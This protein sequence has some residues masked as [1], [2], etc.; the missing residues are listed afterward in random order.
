M[1]TSFI[2]IVFLF[3]SVTQLSAQ[4]ITGKAAFADY[5][6]QKPRVSRKITVADLPEP[7]PA[8]AVDNGPKVVARPEGVMP[9]APPGFTVSIY[10]GGDGGPTPAPDG[11]YS[12]RLGT[13]VPKGT[14]QQPRIIRTAP[15][16]DIFLSDSF[17]GKVYVLR[18]MKADGH[19]AT[20]SL[21]AEELKNPFGIAFYPAK[22]PKWVYVAN[23][24]T[25]V[26]F[27]YKDGDLVASG[28]PETLVSDLPGYA[29]L[30]GGGHW[31]R[32]VVFTP[33]ESHMLISVGSASNADNADDH[34]NE[35][36]RADVLEFTPEGK[37]VEVYASGIRNCVGEAINPVTGSLWCSTNERDNLGNNLVPDYI[38]SVK[39]GGFYGWPWYYMGGHRDPRLELPCAN[40]TAFYK[41][42]KAP[43]TVEQAK[44]CERKDMAAK[45]ITPDVLL[46][47]HM[48]SLGMTFYTPGAGASGA[49]PKEYTNDGFASEH[50]SWN[51]K[52]RGGYEVVRVP[53]K[54]GIATGAYED[55]LT[56]FVMPDGQTWGRPVG[57]TVMKD[58]SLLVSDDGSRTVWRVAYTGDG[59]SSQT[60]S[61]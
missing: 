46:Q 7:S 54:D 13:F 42:L 23:T 27:P 56:G 26:R 59:K 41:D 49:F 30:R 18:G 5:S 20:V 28:K 55:F 31:T 29:Q 57:V 25:V 9:I 40:G 11:H 60:A 50:G 37:F 48:A 3:A 19:A 52:N 32:D 8:E 38:T 45:V 51:R 34:P 61:R 12:E 47:P 14:F 35:F 24:F 1:K 33:D 15:N 43:L 16:G 44:S 10:A 21:Y 58:G 6:Q 2:S 53:L 39:E 36:H 22:D 17:V 4:T